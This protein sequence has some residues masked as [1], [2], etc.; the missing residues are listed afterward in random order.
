MRWSLWGVGGLVT[1]WAPHM[2]HH[3]NFGLIRS[4]LFSL[5][6]CFVFLF[7][8][9]VVIGLFSFIPKTLITEGTKEIKI[10]ETLLLCSLGCY[11]SR[12]DLR[13]LGTDQ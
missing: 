11:T 13:C 12:G 6:F 9:T 5:G 1:A 3:F 7:S 4:P 10:S 8:I 2:P